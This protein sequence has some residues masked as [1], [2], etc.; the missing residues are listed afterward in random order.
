VPRN[1]IDIKKNSQ[2][3]EV[4]YFDAGCFAIYKYESF[5]ESDINFKN[6]SYR[7][8]ILP[9]YAAIDVDEMEDMHLVE[10]LFNAKN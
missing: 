5:L 7:P 10:K 3:F 6:I 8:F 4:T 9:K 2:D 1:M